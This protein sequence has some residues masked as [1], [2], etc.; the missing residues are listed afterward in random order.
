MKNRYEFLESSGKLLGGDRED[1]YG[2]ARENFTRIADLWSPVLS[3]EITTTQVALCLALLKISRLSHNTT[4][5][6]L[7]LDLVGYA[8]L[9]GEMSNDPYGE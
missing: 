8:A 7:W 6:D 5:Q 4:H 9:G 3:I 2:D 1:E